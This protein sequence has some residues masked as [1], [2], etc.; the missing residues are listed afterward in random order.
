M[1]AALA[2]VISPQ[3]LSPSDRND[4]GALAHTSRKISFT[5]LEDGQ[6][7]RLEQ[8]FGTAGFAY[9]WS[10]AQWEERRGRQNKNNFISLR[11]ALNDIKKVD[12]PWM[13]DVPKDIPSEAVRDLT[14]AFKN[15]FEAR[16]AKSKRAQYPRK[17]RKGRCQF[18]F[19]LPA[20]RLRFR[21]TSEK[22]K[23][24][25]EVYLSTLDWVRL[26]ESFSPTFKILY[27]TVSRQADRYFV[28]FCMAYQPIKKVRQI[29][30]PLCIGVDLDLTNTVTL[31]NGSTVRSPRSPSQSLDMLAK[32]NK[33]LHRKEKG[34]KNRRKAAQKVARLHSDI[35]NIRQDFT[36]QLS[37]QLLKK[38][39]I[40][41][42]ED[43]NVAAMIKSGRMSRSLADASLGALVGALERKQ[44]KYGALV[45]Q[46]DRFFPSSQ[47]CRKC[48]VK[49]Q[50][51][52]LGDRIFRCVSPI[53][54]HQEDRLG[55]NGPIVKRTRQQRASDETVHTGTVRSERRSQHSHRA[56][57]LVH[58]AARNIHREELRILPRA[59]GEVRPVEV[60]SLPPTSSDGG[61]KL[62]L[63]SRKQKPQGSVTSNATQRQKSA[64]S[65]NLSDQI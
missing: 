49:N 61:G 59:T 17:K 22:E 29:R 58:D 2:Q 1:S 14:V 7:Q 43:L 11:N 8:A 36:E 9:N 30:K 60:W 45:I 16:K 4:G 12:C 33:S 54:Q 44:T 64:R 46:V 5:L 47:L 27:A 57:G 35:A 15:F 55:M 48:Q 28:S 21:E 37:T 3:I 41:G 10:L 53:C 23:T 13:L 52:T 31:S 38:Y 26:K 39:D 20:D 56:Y 34:S 32:S 40:I 6:S 25:T 24:F 62:C 63:G 18:S 19:R 42:I 65:E 50:D 51:L